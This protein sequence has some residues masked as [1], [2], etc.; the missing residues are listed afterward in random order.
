MKKLMLLILLTCFILINVYSQSTIEIT[1]TGIDNTTYIQLDSIKVMNQTQGGETTLVWP[2]TVLILDVQVGITENNN[3]KEDLEVFQNYPNPVKDHTSLTLFISEKG[4]VSLLISDIMGRQITKLEKELSSGYHTFEFIPGTGEIFIL[5]AIWKGNHRSI[6]ILTTPDRSNQ[7]S[8]LQYISSENDDMNLK[9]ITDIQEFE[10]NLGDQ[11][12]YIGYYE[13]I[14]TGRIDI[15]EYGAKPTF[16]LQFA[17][18]IPCPGVETVN[19]G[20]QVYNTIQ[21][22]GQCWLKENLN[23][24]TMILGSVE[25]QNNGV[26]EKYCYDDDIEN[27]NNYGGLYQWDEM[28]NYTVTQGAQGIC[29]PGWH[30]PA[31]E[32][33]GILEGS[34]DTQY[35]IGDPVWNEGGYIGQDV[36]TK[37]KSQFGWINSGNG[38]DD[39]GYSILPGGYH[40]LGNVYLNVEYQGYLWSSYKEN[41]YDLPWY[42]IYLWNYTQLWRNYWEIDHGLSVRCI[43]D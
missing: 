20:G 37:L 42:R 23:I 16:I 10:Y 31:K 7:K 24:G 36:A 8:S 29:P 5:T 38:T 27:C 33:W 6:K 41:D 30:V 25:M 32:D 43:K 2:D 39:F 28:M 13:G 35:G 19:Y 3:R 12:L 9:T 4:D 34:V 15:P 40:H 14:E 18:N 1:F 22:R 11:L 21:I 17:D 26:I